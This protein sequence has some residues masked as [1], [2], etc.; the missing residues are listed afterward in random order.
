MH[1]SRAFGE[2]KLEFLLSRIQAFAAHRF[3]FTPLEFR[4][5]PKTLFARDCRP[6][7]AKVV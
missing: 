6:P 5:T 3:K 1:H 7:E 4:R 2:V